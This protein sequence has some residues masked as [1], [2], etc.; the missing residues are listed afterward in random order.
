MDKKNTRILN[1]LK[2]A[3]Q[4][5][6]DGHYFYKMAAGKTKD[7]RGREA[8][9]L[10]AKDELEHFNYLKEQYDSLLETGRPAK[11]AKIAK[12]KGRTGKSPIF[13]KDF[14]KRIAKA[15]FELSALS[16]AIGLE[17]S[18]L[19]FYKRE[20]EKTSDPILKD[21]FGKLASWEETHHQILARE[22]SRLQ[23]D[24]WLEN[25]FYPF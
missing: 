9:L 25:R 13:S 8:L 11:K 10:L 18:S 4:A 12:P 23:E 21:F 3:M 7:A 6:T 19:N 15:H 16:I 1:A 2:S 17:L 20:A 14:K 22:Q 24:Y 5:E